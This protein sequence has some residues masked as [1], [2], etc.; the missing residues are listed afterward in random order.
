[1]LIK[2]ARVQNDTPALSESEPEHES[3]K[4]DAGQKKD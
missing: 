3:N 1:M 4:I 2:P